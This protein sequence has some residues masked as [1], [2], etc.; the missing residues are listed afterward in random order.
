MTIL[1]NGK[2]LQQTLDTSIPDSEALLGC[3]KAGPIQ[4][5]NC[6]GLDQ[7]ID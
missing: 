6:L 5:L 4:G 7:K 3:R 1:P 2:E